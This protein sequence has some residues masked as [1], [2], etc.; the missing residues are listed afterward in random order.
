MIYLNSATRAYG[1]LGQ[2]IDSHK[3]VFAAAKPGLMNILIYKIASVYTHAVH[4]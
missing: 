1:K 2:A 3:Y 4:L